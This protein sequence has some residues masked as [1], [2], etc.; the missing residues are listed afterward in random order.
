MKHDTP[1]MSD[2]AINIGINAALYHHTL[3]RYTVELGVC[4]RGLQYAIRDAAI[5]ST[6]SMMTTEHS[7]DGIL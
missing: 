2:D 3:W 5:K 6:E 1:P 7:T 4:Q